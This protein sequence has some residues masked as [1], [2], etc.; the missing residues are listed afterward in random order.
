M[1]RRAML[2]PAVVGRA[3]RVQVAHQRRAAR[4]LCSLPAA[5]CTTGGAASAA[6]ELGGALAARN[7]R[8][9]ECPRTAR[10]FTTRGERVTHKYVRLFK[11]PLSA[12]FADVARFLSKADVVPDPAQTAIITGATRAH[13]SWVVRVPVHKHKH[14]LALHGSV[15]SGQVVDVRQVCARCSAC[16]THTGESPSATT[17]PPA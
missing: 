13:G 8:L 3:L 7:K 11:L 16:L 1:L 14:V 15:V 6:V 9:F 4:R 10:T 5:S 12:T 17:I 2:V